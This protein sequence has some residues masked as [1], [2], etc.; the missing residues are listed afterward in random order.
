MFRVRYDATSNNGSSTGPSYVVKSYELLILIRA[1]SICFDSPSVCFVLAVPF[2]VGFVFLNFVAVG[3]SSTAALPFG[4]ILVVMTLFVFVALPLTILGAIA[5]K[6]TGAFVAPC[7]TLKV[8][9]LDFL[10]VC[11]IAKVLFLV[12][13][14]FQNCL[15]CLFCLP[16][17][18][19]CVERTGSAANVSGAQAT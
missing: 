17:Q 3:H 16:R 11:I 12:R 2:A 15:F 5:G 13:V 19:A 7:R 18:A 8:C 4:T 10:F 9:R 1:R 14:S 6:R